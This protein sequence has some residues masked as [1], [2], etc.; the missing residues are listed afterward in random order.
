MAC[1]DYMA[2]NFVLDERTAGGAKIKTLQK[3]V[4]EFLK[5]EHEVDHLFNPRSVEFE[6]AVNSCAQGSMWSECV[7]AAASWQTIQA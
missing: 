4:E 5:V 6:A 3:Q 7:G 2:S 1:R